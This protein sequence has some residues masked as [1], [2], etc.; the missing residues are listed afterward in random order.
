MSFETVQLPALHKREPSDSAYPRVL[1]KVSKRSGVLDQGLPYGIIIKKPIAITTWPISTPVACHGP[2]YGTPGNG[3]EPM[4]KTSA[5]PEKVE[6][7]KPV[8]TRRR[9]M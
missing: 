3:C 8:P 9:P 2:K 6:I 1:K 7:T 5:M 4:P